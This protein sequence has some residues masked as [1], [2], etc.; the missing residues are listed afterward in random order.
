MGVTWYVSKGSIVSSSQSGTTYSVVIQWTDNGTA[1]IEIAYDTDLQIS[2]GI[3]TV[4]I[5]GTA[6]P[7]MPVTTFS[8][9]S[10]CGST[11]ITRNSSPTGTV[12]WYWQTT[13]TGI[14]TANKTATYILSA[15]GV[16]YLRAQLIA[17]PYT[18]SS[19][20]ATSTI[21][22]QTQ[23]A[24]PATS[25]DGHV[26]SS[27]A[28]AIPI[29][30]SAVSGATSYNWHEHPTESSVISSA[31]STNTWSPVRST[32]KSYYVEAVTGT[33]TSPARKQVTAFVHPAPV[34]TSEDGSLN[35]GSQAVLNATQY[36][37][38]SYQ[39]KNAVTDAIIPGQTSSTFTTTVAGK[40]KV[41]VTKGNA[42]PYTTADFTVGS[43]LTGLNMNYVVS[44]KILVE[45]IT[46]SDA[47]DALSIQ[48]K[49]QSIQYFD[50]LGAPIQSIV[51][52]GSPLMKDVV[53]Q[54]VYDG[55]GREHRKY[56]PVVVDRNSGWYKSGIVNAT[57]AYS[58][59]AANFYAN[60]PNGK[61]AQDNN[62]Y[63]QT[64]FEASPLN[65]PLREYGAGAAWSTNYK[66]IG[67][68]YRFNTHSV[69]ASDTAERIIA[70]KIITNMPVR[71]TAV[72]NHILTG[73]YYANNQLSIKI[74]ID[75]QGNMVR[76]YTNKAGQVILKKVQA[77]AGITDLSHATAWAL[78]YYVYDDVGNLRVVMPP[79]LSRI[80]HAA[81]DS[82]VVSGTDLTNWA[83]QYSYDAKKRMII[84]QVP[85]S[86]QV[87]MVYDKRDRVVLTQDANQRSTANKYWSFTKYDDL[88]RPI[89]TGIKDTAAILT[90]ADM[91]ARVDA[92]YAKAWTRLGEK[93]I[94]TATGNMHGYTNKSYPVVTGPTTTNDK[95][96]YLSVTYYDNYNFKATLPDSGNYTFTTNHLSGQKIAF[97]KRVT[98]QVTG[99]KIKVLDGGIAGGYTWLKTISYFDDDYR[100]IQSV[101]D[102]YKAGTDRTT[103][104]YDFG[105]KVLQTRSTHS[106]S[107]VTWK[108]LVNVKLNGNNL[109]G[110][111]TAAGA[112][113][114]QQLAAGVNGWLEVIY[115][116]GNTTRFI[117]LNDA[118]PDVSAA[119]INYAFRFTATNTANVYENNTVKATISN[120]KPGDIFR[121]AR[122]GTVVKYYRNNVEITLSPASTASSTL[123]MADAC[124]TTANGTLTNVRTSFSTTAQTVTRRFEYDHA[125]RLLKTWHKLNSDSI[126]LVKNEYN[127]LGQL[128][129]KKLHSTLTSGADAKQSVD[130][131]YNIR[132]WLTKLNES[133]VSVPVS[134]E[135]KDLFGMQL[136]YND[137]IG[138]SATALYNGNISAVKWSNNLSAGAVKENAYTYTYDAMN[139]L[140]TSVFKEKAATWTTP[141][142]NANAETGF[143]YDLNGNIKT[144]QR[145]D[146][147]TSGLMMDNLT[148]T[149][150]S[151]STLSNKLLKVADAGDDFTGFMDGSD[152]AAEYSYDGNGNMITDLNKG[153]ST[154][155][156]YN[157]L[158]LPELVTK[159]NNTINYIYDVSG[160]KLTQL[161]TY[162]GAQKQTDYVGEYQYENDV[163]QHISHEEGRIVT[164]K[165]ETVLTHSADVTT[166][167]T[168]V[169]ATLTAMTQNGTEKYVRATSTGTIARTG[170][171]PIGGTLTVAAGETYRIRAK[172]YR[173]GASPVYLQIKA[174]GA[175]LNWPGAA[176][177]FGVTAESWT[178]QT[179]TI[180]AGATTLQAGV[181][182]NTVTNGEQFFLNAFEIIKVSTN[183]PEYQYNLKDHLGNTRI[184]FTS[185]EETLSQTAT[186]E[187]P[188]TDQSQ[189]LR[190]SEAKRIQSFLF[191]KTNGSKPSN[192]TGYSQR[193]NGSANERYGLGKSVSVMPGDVIYTEVYAKYVD[194]A[195]IDPNTSEGQALLAL[196]SAIGSGSAG[197]VVDGANYMGSTSSF[198]FPAAAIQN[199]SASSEAGP[200]AYLNWL[201]FDRDFNF[202]VGESG[203]DR[204]STTPKETGQDVTHELLY[205]PSITI[206]QAGYVYIYLSNEETSPLEVYFDN[207]KVT[208]QK[209]PVVQSDDYYAFGLT[210]NSY[211]RENNL[212][213]KYQYNGKEKQVTLD[214]NWLDYGA[215]F[216]DP[217]IARW[218][219]V[220]PLSEKGR[221]WSPYNYAFNSPV[222]FID[223]D[224]MWPD[225]GKLAR[226]AYDVASGVKDAVLSNATTVKGVDGSTLVEG[227]AR[228]AARSEAH[229]VGMALG[230]VISVAGG[231]LEA[232]VGGTAVAGGVTVSG[233]GAGAIVGV[234]AAT[235]GLVI[236]AHGVSTAKNGL[237]NLLKSDG[238]SN[239]GSGE[240]RG[241]NNRKPDSEAT[242]DHTVSNDRGSTTYQKN[243]KNPSGFQEVK[244]VDTK[245][246]ADNGVPTP[247]VH[248]NGK[249][250]PANPDEIPK[251]D[252]SKNKR[253]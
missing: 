12:N 138:V 47:I 165:T 144:L 42:S 119:N 231:L 22:V 59:I 174:N 150:G 100:V 193:L 11:T 176:L 50:G 209:S 83:F 6:A 1:S 146:K 242:G 154:A 253:N 236:A 135:A 126:L 216:Y 220:D 85:G 70:W 32:T 10:S 107:D 251:T 124:Y 164:A 234:P 30:V 230:D 140:S 208:H 37:Y 76:E 221:R 65:R 110:T 122:T 102:N 35:M 243:E 109:I 132:G 153:L 7:P 194:P 26:I 163:L 111:T 215:R 69:T 248:E 178:E 96:R 81:A 108:D 88:N 112:A 131:A 179:V 34:I 238:K 121:I 80:I 8:T 18:W 106:E 237:D 149:Y 223:P 71:Q 128:V 240:G 187:N 161:T 249:V 200:K 16:V 180:P 195:S 116:E 232:A 15:T 211:Q 62:P 143:T 225:W 117:G 38:D 152:V 104:R 226:N 58:S 93:Y 31:P 158:N 4:T 162:S 105:G 160:R 239:Q 77:I 54:S 250:R 192:V 103:S 133:D 137:D 28:L 214:L 56:L 218:L 199:T 181:V 227:Y 52:Q 123:L 224:G 40:Y 229:D 73:G 222:N 95:D 172:G 210:F 36:A 74:T 113:S 48:Q 68:E 20:K 212:L 169:N 118:N 27:S 19:A 45:G 167:I 125:G 84:K 60:N 90:Q 64:V 14:S 190:V 217:A 228:P 78:T 206:K 44:N 9:V 55:F 151:G 147:R 201:V 157:I 173:M 24:T 23:P 177:A 92:H 252:L 171:Y 202:I 184:T 196:L 197:V 198:P 159:G 244:R 61:I 114:T 139:R 86:G 13:S 66:F 245:G 182:W 99:T 3:K 129:D 53:Q 155:I 29:S 21:T 168:G 2:G 191:D 49:S 247:H 127:E 170:M 166:G 25:T 82:Y 94:G 72:A 51:T 136:G 204:L 203:Y 97:F 87:Y 142:S 57:G 79:E 17:A 120:V 91:Q 130:Y 207:F 115:S 41:Q 33:C 175:D 235:G 75:E 148:Y 5:T 156:T 141:G 205:S 63:S 186:L 145:N 89:L 189:F 213:N 43:G 101:T 39:W 233:T 246:K 185:K 183:A 188:N 67:Y 46:N 219:V 241:K 98:G 134:G